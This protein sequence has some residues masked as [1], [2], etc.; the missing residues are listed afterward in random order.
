MNRN[1]ADAA[2]DLKRVIYASLSSS[3]FSSPNVSHF[4]QSA[5]KIVKANKNHLRKDRFNQIKKIISQGNNPLIPEIK[6]RDD[7]L[8]AAVMLQNE[9]TLTQK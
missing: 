9:F 8:M 4:L 1:L 3:G 7:L 5:D 6:R 2:S